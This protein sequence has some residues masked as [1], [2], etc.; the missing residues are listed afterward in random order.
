[1]LIQISFL[2]NHLCQIINDQADFLGILQLKTTLQAPRKCHWETHTYVNKNE[3][4]L[5]G[6]A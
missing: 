3:E 2:S 4:Q 1:M 6:F 5:G